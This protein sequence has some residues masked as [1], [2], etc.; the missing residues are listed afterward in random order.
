VQSTKGEAAVMLEQFKI[1]AEL[2]HYLRM[3]VLIRPKSQ[4]LIAH[5]TLRFNAQHDCRAGKCPIVEI[6]VW[7]ERTKTTKTEKAIQHAEMQR[8]FL[9]THALHNAHLIRQSPP[10]TF[11]KPRHYLED[12]CW[13]ADHSASGARSSTGLRCRNSRC[14]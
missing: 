2:D 3:P 1:A 8:Y 13:L 10:R 7:H 5:I 9:N 12:C 6:P 4:S 14:E 11:V